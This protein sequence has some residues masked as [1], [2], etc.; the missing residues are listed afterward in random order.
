MKGKFA[1]WCVIGIAA[2]AL[3]QWV[4]GSSFLSGAGGPSI[5]EDSPELTEVNRKADECLSND[6][7]AHLSVACRLVRKAFGSSPVTDLDA[8]TSSQ[9]SAE[10]QEAAKPLPM[11]PPKKRSNGRGFEI[12]SMPSIDPEA[13]TAPL[14]KILIPEEFFLPNGNVRQ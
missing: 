2:Y 12:P 6:D 11:P 1:T 9:P 13:A 7:S 5:L 14:R 4:R 3:C 10:P 8:M